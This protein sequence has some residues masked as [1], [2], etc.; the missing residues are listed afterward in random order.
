VSCPPPHP[1]GWFG[2]EKTKP[3]DLNLVESKPIKSCEARPFP[4]WL[5]SLIASVA[6]GLVTVG[7]HAWILPAILVEPEFDAPVIGIT[8][9]LDK[10]KA[11]EEV[12][13]ESLP[14][15]RI[16]PVAPQLMV[17]IP[18]PA[19]RTEVPRGPELSQ[20]QV[21]P[22]D[23]GLL[24]E[25]D[26]EGSNPLGKKVAE[27]PKPKSKPKS[28][29]LPRPVTDAIP[30]KGPSHPARVLRRYE[31]DYPRSARRDKVEGRVI[32]DVQIGSRGRVGSVRV[33]SS[34]GSPVL[35]STAIAAVKRWSFTPAR[36]G[37]K[38]VSSQ[39]HVPFRFS[40]Q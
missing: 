32:L 12:V 28:R 4:F 23:P 11:V 33:L 38:P 36:K 26:P 6:L 13:P 10:K 31:P 30:V 14:L 29:S 17:P 39:V 19:V 40:L 7:L 16:P 1:D 34:S 24:V 27:P 22:Y 2:R 20:D 25:L 35:D 8:R 3:V 5:S 9:L 18:V 21:E 15:T 37:G